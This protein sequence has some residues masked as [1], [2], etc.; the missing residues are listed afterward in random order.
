[1]G[2]AQTLRTLR[3]NHRGAKV[4]SFGIVSTLFSAQAANDTD[5]VL[6]SRKYGLTVLSTK[7]RCTSGAGALRI[8]RR[9]PEQQPARVVISGRMADVCAA[10]DELANREAENALPC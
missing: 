9:E 8:L 1:M 4:D 5:S 10:L 3:I 2:L 7:P 6:A